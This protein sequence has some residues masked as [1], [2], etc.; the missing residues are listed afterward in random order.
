MSENQCS[1]EV[2]DGWRYHRCSRKATVERDGRLYCW[3][4]SPLRVAKKKAEKDAEVQAKLDTIEE[5]RIRKENTESR[6]NALGVSTV[7][8]LLDL[9][10]KQE[11][12][13]DDLMMMAR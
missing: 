8:E 2:F 9:A 13:I 1:G 3:Q 6:M 10:E 7:K 12:E 5:E 11:K 4:H